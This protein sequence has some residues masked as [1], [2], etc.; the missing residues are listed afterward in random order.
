[1]IISEKQ[2]M[3]L[4][5]IAIEK[6][7]RLMLNDAAWT[8]GICQDLNSLIDDIINQQSTELKVVE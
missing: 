3:Q 2:I 7:D 8:T 1:M 5:E 4:L 6:R